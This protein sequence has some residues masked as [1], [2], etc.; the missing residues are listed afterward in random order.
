MSRPRS[1]LADA[2]A[3]AGRRARLRLIACL[4]AAT[5]S[6]GHVAQAA[7]R[8]WSY[9]P[10]NAETRRVAG[11]LTFEFRQRFMFQTLLRVLATDAEATAELRPSSERQLGPGGLRALIG[12]TAPQRDVYEINA[13]AAQGSAMIA[14]LCPGARRAFLAFGRMRAFADMRIYALGADAAGSPRLCRTLE[15]S[16]HGDWRPPPTGHIDERA[17]EPSPFPQ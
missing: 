10:A 16:F 1:R 4:V 15:F 2:Q 14:A 8:I 17:L 9:D 6:L 12:P 5:A 3:A 11:R 7:I 13:K